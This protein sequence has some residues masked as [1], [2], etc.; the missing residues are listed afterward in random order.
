MKEN[1]EQE[2]RNAHRKPVFQSLLMG[3]ILRNFDVIVAFIITKWYRYN[4]LDNHLEMD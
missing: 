2:E 1:A 3:L 4:V